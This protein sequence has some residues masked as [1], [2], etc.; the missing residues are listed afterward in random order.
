MRRCFLLVGLAGLAL[1]LGCNSGNQAY[2]EVPKGTRVKDQPHEHETG[3]HNGHLVELGEEEYH[4]EVVFDP[5]TAKITIYVLD[6]TAKKPTPIDAKEIKL[7]LTIGGQPKPLTAKAVADAGDSANKS[8]RF[9]VTDNPEIKAN[10]KDEEDL[11]GSVTV[12]IG[13]KT[14]TGKIVHEH[15]H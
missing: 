6:S 4:G 12:P 7:E 3:P 13:T 9:E 15:G 2:H 8:S 10:I 14:Y 11:K 1:F 5:K